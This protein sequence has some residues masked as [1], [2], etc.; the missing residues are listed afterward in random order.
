MNIKNFDSL[1]TNPLRNKALLIADAG[2][3]AI[4]PENA[5][6]QSVSFDGSTFTAGKEK[7]DI[8]KFRNIYVV[9]IGKA[10]FQAAKYIEGILGKRIVEGAIIDVAVG[11]LKYIRSHE[12]TH[13]FPTEK[14]IEATK[15]IVSILNKAEKDD[16]V[17]AIISGGGSSLLCLPNKLVC[18][19]LQRI[20]DILFKRGAN[21]KEMNTVRKHISQIH[22]G[23]MAKLAY[24]ATVV[25][26][27]FSDIPF[28]DLSFVASGPTYLDKTSKED[29]ARVAKKYKLGKLPLCETPKSDRYFKKVKNVLV[30]SNKVALKAMRVKAKELGFEPIV[31]GSCLKG[32]AR[33]L[34]KTLLGKAKKGQAFLSGGETTVVIKKKGKGGR[35]LEL[36]LGALPY[37]KKGEVIISVSSDGKDHIKEAAGAIGDMQLVDLM[38]KA[39]YDSEFYLDEN[40]SFEF[41]TDLQGVIVTNQTG[42]NVSDLMI[43]VKE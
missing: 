37:L 27:I 5:L 18:A 23:N 42:S 11:K 40:R 19:D 20:T 7:F 1:A 9:G 17:I 16:L 21:I 12:G 10:S 36:V 26:L 6:K 24:P 30:L 4:L 25:G 15:D 43:V 35:N 22:G 14:N 2:I 8:S 13:P 28:S 32:E 41:F 29:A 34:G 33:K 39:G 31:C 38:K 3:E